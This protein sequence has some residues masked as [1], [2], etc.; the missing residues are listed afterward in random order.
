[1]KPVSDIVN[2]LNPL[3]LLIAAQAF[4]VVLGKTVLEFNLGWTDIV[5]GLA[6]A[7][8]AELLFTYIARRAK[9]LP[10]ELF[11][12]ASA[13]AAAL[14]I[15]IFFRA[16]DPI[17][18]FLAALVAVGS[19]YVLK[20]N[21]K[22]IFNPSN[23]AVVVLVF[24]FPSAA[25]V[26]F[27]QWGNSL[28]VYALVAA[29]CFFISYRAG[30]WITTL[31]FL[32]SYTA[33]LLISV[34]FHLDILSVH[35]YGILG[36]SLV[37]FASFMITD[38]RTSPTGTYPRILHGI[39]VAS[40]FF[41]LEMLGVKY[42]LFVASFGVT[43]LTLLSAYAMRLVPTKAAALPKNSLACLFL[44]LAMGAAYVQT[45]RKDGLYVEFTRVSPAFLLMGVESPSIT[46][47][48]KTP[49]FVPDKSF[50]ASAR[51]TTGAS[52]GD[53]D[54]D[55][56]DDL[57]VSS[58][59]EPSRLYRNTPLG[60]VDTT[61]AAGLPAVNSQSAFF[62]DYDNDG[63]RDLFVVQGMQDYRTA[64]D[65]EP[66]AQ[67]PK[68][69]AVRVFKNTGSGFSETTKALGLNAFT[70]PPGGGTLS[71]ADYDSDGY[72]DFVYAAQANYY[73]L[74]PVGNWA[75]LK[76]FFEPYLNTQQ[77]II[78]D[79]AVVTAILQKYGPP[80]FAR[81][82]ARDAFVADGGCM[83]TVERIPLTKDPQA[84]HHN[85]DDLFFATAYKPG[86]A[87]LFTNRGGNGFT[88]H[89]P[90]AAQLHALYASSTGQSFSTAEHPYDAVSNSFYQPV[91]FDY[92]QDGRQDIFLSVDWGTNLLMRNDGRLTFSNMTAE[93]GM[94]FYGDGMG[95][96][97]GDYSG[98]GLQDVAVSNISKTELYKNNGN[99]TFT[100]E[101][102]VHRLNPLSIA[103]GINLFDYDNDGRRDLFVGNG[104]VETR[105]DL[106]RL[107][108]TRALYRSDKLYRRTA[109]GFADVTAQGFCP[110]DGQLTRPSAVA[111]YDN[112]GYPDLFVGYFAF[113]VARTPPTLY[114]NTGTGAHYIAVNLTGTVSNADAV[115]AV[116]SVTAGG[117]TQT[118]TVLLGSSFYAQS[119]HRLLF[120]LGKQTNPVDITVLWPSGIKTV[121]TAVPV[122]QLLT[123]T[124]KR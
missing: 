109:T 94:N 116:V 42:A 49:A 74:S 67:K 4:F 73:D 121:S 6:T 41:L 81:A 25:T 7:V 123:I 17:Y 101:R 20:A 72:L 108:L 37:L 63:R 26:E 87:H 112:D 32:L 29:I 14:G 59:D 83:L 82:A 35:H 103:W 5:V 34:P 19:K 33:L 16:T 98:D 104:N 90:F 46:Q 93:A 92:N 88:E 100:D 9:G 50:N 13:V 85:L 106:P 65:G 70:L 23:I 99:G 38:P 54:S 57:F 15:A 107:D 51:M 75:L 76:A 91:S 30:A 113:G 79:S 64:V 36:P 117:T 71:F 124:E 44:V 119:S 40:A 1:M 77:Q 11:F 48:S 115:G 84:L 47:C 27:T 53:Y 55:G 110:A 111:D 60:F 2:G 105:S 102:W 61:T 10:F 80:E 28:W 22:H 62:A 118:Q 8:A 18:F 114:R 122:D 68:V 89:A 78:C 31:S 45:I 56:R 39:G 3:Y 52:W 86:S 24:A 95:A 58:I 120:G 12:P 21:G 43:V 97:V 96:D 66:L 69:T